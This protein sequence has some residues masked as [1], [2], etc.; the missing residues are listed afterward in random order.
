MRIPASAVSAGEGGET[1]VFAFDS[2]D[3]ETGSLR[4]VPIDLAMGRDGGFEVL[5]GLATRQ[6]IVAAGVPVLTDGPQSRRFT[7]FRQ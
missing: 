1:S 3:G 4:R 7:E 5:A 2:T 6:E